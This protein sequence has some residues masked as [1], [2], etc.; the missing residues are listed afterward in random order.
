[1]VIILSFHVC[2][3]ISPHPMYCNGLKYPVLI[4]LVILTLSHLISLH[5]INKSVNEWMFSKIINHLENINRRSHQRK[6]LTISI[7]CELSFLSWIFYP[8]S[9]YKL[10]Y[11]YR[12]NLSLGF[13]SGRKKLQSKN[14]V[15]SLDWEKWHR[16][17]CDQYYVLVLGLK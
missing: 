2:L 14:K 7:P 4:I 12:V 10:L 9:R 1:M 8:G 6:C 17:L 3:P 13:A 11:K 15:C 5:G 16:S